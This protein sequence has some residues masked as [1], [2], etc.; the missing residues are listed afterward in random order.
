[1]KY[2]IS[3]LH[4]MY[5]LYR[6]MLDRLALTEE[7]TLYVLGDVFDRGPHPVKILLD[8]MQRDNVIPILGNHEWMGMKCLRFL[9]EEI[10]DESILRMDEEMIENLQ[11]WERNGNWSTLQEMQALDSWDREMVLDYIEGFGLWEEVEAGGKQFLLV[12]GGLANF[13]PR[14]SL[15]D[16]TVEELVWDRPDYSRVYF[17]DKYLVTGH[18]PTGY[19]PGNPRAEYIYQANHHIAID[20]GAVFTGRLGAICLDTL[21]EIYVTEEM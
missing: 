15:Y 8:M 10:T 18:T 16:Y 11:I 4:G 20:C 19:I 12:H 7:D 9:L 21:E 1:M 2:V 5:D 3:D 17:P 13:S 14:K 6:K